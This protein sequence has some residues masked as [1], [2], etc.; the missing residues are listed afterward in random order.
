M[1]FVHKLGCTPWPPKEDCFSNLLKALDNRAL[2]E[3]LQAWGADGGGKVSSKL[4]QFA[5][6]PQHLFALF[7]IL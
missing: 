3:M 2:D 4:R 5:C 1:D 7:G 6:K